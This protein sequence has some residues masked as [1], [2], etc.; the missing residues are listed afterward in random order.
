V[1]LLAPGAK[2]SESAIELGIRAPLLLAASHPLFHGLIAVRAPTLI[3]HGIQKKT[4]RLAAAWARHKPR[5][6]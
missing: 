3:E 5:V 6:R 4:V 2:R 1:A